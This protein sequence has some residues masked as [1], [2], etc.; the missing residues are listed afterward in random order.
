MCGRFASFRDAQELVDLFEVGPDGVPDEVTAITPSWN[1]A[2]TDPVRIV[3][4]RHPRD[5][6]G[7][8]ER[9]LRAARWGLVP[10]W[11]KE[12]SIGSRMINARSETVADK[13]AFRAALRARRCLVPAEGWYEWHRPGA[14]AR[15]P[16]HPYWIHPEDG[17]PLALAGL[18]EFWR[19]P[20][21]ADD[22]PGR[23]LV[24]TTVVTADASA[25]P[26]L[27]PVHARR[28]VAL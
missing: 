3:V 13:P 26:V 6:Q 24:T 1:V 17:G 5:G 10:S 8:A 12:R 15:G 4:E 20:A 21:R 11:A 23:W 18:F 9:S 25:D 28:P 2:P 22:D 16:K 27:G 7:P 14:A 19:D